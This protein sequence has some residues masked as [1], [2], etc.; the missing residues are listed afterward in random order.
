MSDRKDILKEQAKQFQNSV[1]DETR[2]KLFK[3]MQA[4]SAKKKVTDAAKSDSMDHD[5]L[6]STLRNMMD[7][8]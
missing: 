4:G 1:S 6:L 7:D 3:A 5:M 2:Q 8:K